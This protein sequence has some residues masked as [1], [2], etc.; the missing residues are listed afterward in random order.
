[1]FKEEKESIIEEEKMTR[2]LSSL[3]VINKVYGVLFN[4]SRITLRCGNNR[5]NIICFILCLTISLILVTGN[6]SADMVYGH[7]KNSGMADSGIKFYYKGDK[8]ESGN[9]TI[10][11]KGNYSINLKEEGIYKVVHENGMETWIKSSSSPVR[12]DLTFK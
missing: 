5:M 7:V 3:S 11:K 10:D 2:D 1:M 6:A 12:H 4:F 9:T 8:K